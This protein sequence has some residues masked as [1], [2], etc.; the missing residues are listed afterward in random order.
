LVVAQPPHRL[1]LTSHA[2]PPCLVEP[3]CLDDGDGYFSVETGVI[4]KVDAF[5][6]SFTKEAL[7]L[8]AIAGEGRGIGC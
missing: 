6:A 5:A 7:D 3:L 2:G 8:I 1:R 4:R